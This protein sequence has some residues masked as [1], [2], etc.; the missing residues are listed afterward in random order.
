MQSQCIRYIP[1]TQHKTI[2][3]NQNDSDCDGVGKKIVFIFSSIKIK[4][5]N[6]KQKEEKNSYKIKDKNFET[7]AAHRNLVVCYK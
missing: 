2:I 5:K 3:D 6:I 4:K 7:K 1:Y